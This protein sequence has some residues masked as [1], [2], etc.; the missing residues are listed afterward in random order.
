MLI[1]HWFPLIRPYLT[2]ISQ[3][4]TFGGR[5]TIAMKTRHPEIDGAERRSA[6]I[7]GIDTFDGSEIQWRAPPGIVPYLAKQAK[8]LKLFGMT[9][10]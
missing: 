2:L 10:I 4:V 6:N 9:N 7:N 5:L 8:R 3:G 1:D